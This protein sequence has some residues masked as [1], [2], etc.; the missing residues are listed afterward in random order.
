L[1]DDWLFLRKSTPDFQ[2]LL[3]SEQKSS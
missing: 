2:K 3:D 1:F